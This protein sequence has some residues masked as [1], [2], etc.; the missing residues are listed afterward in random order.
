[1]H[2]V[3]VILNQRTHSGWLQARQRAESG[4]LHNDLDGHL[5]IR[6]VMRV[7]QH[8][9]VVHCTQPCGGT[10][11]LPSVSPCLDFLFGSALFSQP[12]LGAR[13][14]L[15]V[16]VGC[17]GITFRKFLTYRKGRKF[18]EYRAL[19]AEVLVFPFVSSCCRRLFKHTGR[20]KPMCAY[21][22]YCPDT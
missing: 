14:W 13:E 1:M 18:I 3:L 7:W 5:T 12:S 16:I 4:I 20:P 2:L 17:G 22:I 11:T 10:L 19:K 15:L 8:D 6:M 9:F 21:E